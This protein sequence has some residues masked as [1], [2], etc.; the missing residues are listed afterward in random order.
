MKRGL[1]LSGGAFRGAV[2]IP[3]IEELFVRHEYDAIYGVSVGAINGSL[4]AQHEME[5]LREFWDN[6]DGL[7]G[8][9]KSKWY[10][11]FKGFYDMTPLRDKL[12][13]NLSLE[14][15][16]VPFRA[17]TV[18]GTTGEYFN[19][20]TENMTRNSQYWDA[21]QSSSCMAGIMVPGTF[22]HDS[23]THLGF[24]GGYR[25][26][27]P[28]PDEEFDHIDIVTCTPLDRMKMKGEF[29]KVNILAL[30]LR[31]IEIF[32]DEIFDRDISSIIQTNTPSITIYAPQEYPGEALDASRETIK[33]RYE[34]GRE[35]Y[36]NPWEIR[37]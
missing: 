8:F 20:R 28:I 15:V 36:L 7:P 2:Q 5:K 18:S 33:F 1:L 9:F 27:I 21:V 25:S 22:V 35:A 6:V 16:K 24:D 37:K 17:G 13:T 26:I 34:L 19:L 4:M 31:G 10:W 32:E 29:K 14:K 12:E 30:L 3:V 11:P 23:Q